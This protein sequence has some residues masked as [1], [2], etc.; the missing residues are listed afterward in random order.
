ME[1]TKEQLEKKLYSQDD[2][3]L[4]VITDTTRWS[5]QYRFVFRHEGR[6]YETEYSC[7]ATEYQDEGPW[8]YD[9]EVECSEVE[10]YEKSIIDYRQV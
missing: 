1:F 8:E 9:E 2:T 7:G 5:I 10:A 3:L 6:I 4:N